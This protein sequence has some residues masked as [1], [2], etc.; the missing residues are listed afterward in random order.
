MS[1]PSLP[2][3]EVLYSKLNKAFGFLNWWPG[4]TKLEI[5]VGAVLTQQTSWKN[6]EKAISSI[7][8][9]NAMKLETL[10]NMGLRELESLIRPSGFYRQ[11]ARRLK[12]LLL[13]MLK[14]GGVEEF[15]DADAMEIR[16]KLL[17]MNG[18]GKETADSIIL[19]AA[20][21]PIFVI[22][23]YTK[24]ILSRIYGIE[25]SINYDELQSIVENSIKKDLILY[26]DFHAQFV[27]L[28]KRYCKTKPICENC[29]VKSMCN[30]AKHLNHAKIKN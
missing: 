19:Y 7:K 13:N 5:I 8:F 29:P 14:D 12:N 10:A 18:I 17:G 27:E 28:G 22:D 20:E 11:K 1:V 9:V 15:L 2:K 3:L 26:K 24:R 30:Y 23:A 16:K 4:E 6:V 25:E 21:K